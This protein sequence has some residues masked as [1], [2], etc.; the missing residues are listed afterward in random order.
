MRVIGSGGGRPIQGLVEQRM[1]KMRGIGGVG[2][3]IERLFKAAERLRMVQQVDLQAA[4][5]D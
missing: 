2:L 1:Q 4:H 3:R 5:V